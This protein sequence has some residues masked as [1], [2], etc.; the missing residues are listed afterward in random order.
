MTHGYGPRV[1]A[2]FH[3]VRGTAYGLSGNQNFGPNS[4]NR[5]I[6]PVLSIDE[7]VV[8]GT[9][10]CWKDY[11]AL[12]VTIC[13]QLSHTDHLANRLSVSCQSQLL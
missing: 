12:L 1:K 4:A 7:R 9:V 8:K 6:Q 13:R 5:H 3:T 10:I 2:Q 11:V